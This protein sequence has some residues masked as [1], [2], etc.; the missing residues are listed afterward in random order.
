MEKHKKQYAT[1]YK[2]QRL[3]GKPYQAIIK[4]LEAG[5]LE[6]FQAKGGYWKI[7]IDNEADGEKCLTSP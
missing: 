7:R 1:V 5:E 3:T 4:A 6:G 2:F